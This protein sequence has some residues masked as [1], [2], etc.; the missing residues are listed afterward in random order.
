M[1]C[2]PENHAIRSNNLGIKR[3]LLLNCKNYLIKCS[4]F[5][6]RMFNDE[7]L[8]VITRELRDPAQTR[9]PQVFRFARSCRVQ[10]EVR[11]Q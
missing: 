3:L 6:H 10:P 1:P 7:H 11:V 4:L 2:F 5:R 9:Y 8:S